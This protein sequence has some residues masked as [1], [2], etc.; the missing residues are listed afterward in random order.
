MYASGQPRMVSFLYLHFA[1]L[2]LGGAK[3]Y[4]AVV[5]DLTFQYLLIYEG[6]I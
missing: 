5:L 4:Q 3:S 6:I 1:E 2:I